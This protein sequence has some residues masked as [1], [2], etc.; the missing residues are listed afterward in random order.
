MPLVFNAKTYTADSY[1]SDSV[2]YIGAAK[3]LSVDDDL[4]LNRTDPKPTSVFS[5]VARASSKMTRTLTLTG[6]LTPTGTAILEIKVSVPVGAASADID[7]LLNDMGAHLSHA[8]FK[9]FVKT[10]KISF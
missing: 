6:A 8:D 7:A 10:Q 5:G 4:F 2:G 3:T 9:T 1:A